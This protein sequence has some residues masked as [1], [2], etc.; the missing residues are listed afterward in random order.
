[1]GQEAKD[2]EMNKIKYILHNDEYNTNTIQKKQNPH[3]DTQDQK[4][5]W[6]TFT[7]NG[8]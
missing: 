2:I 1:M 8:K 4:T 5:K 6:V 7:Y 3:T